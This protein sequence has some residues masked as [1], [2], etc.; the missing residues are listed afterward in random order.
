METRSKHDGD[1]RIA[2]KVWFLDL[3]A[4]YTGVLCGNSSSY[5]TMIRAL[6]KMRFNA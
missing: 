6:L 1:M 3:D 2:N 4:V 5:K